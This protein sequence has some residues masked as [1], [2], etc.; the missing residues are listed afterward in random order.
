[1]GFSVCTTA[2]QGQCTT[3]G[4]LDACK[5][6]T[7]GGPQPLPYP[8]IGMCSDGDGSSK[9]R[10]K[11]KNALRKGDKMSKSMG[12]NAGVA[13]G[14][15]KSNKFMG[16]VA[17]KN[18]CAKVKAEGKLWAHHTVP[19]EH[20]DGNTVGLQSVPCAPQVTLV[21]PANDNANGTDATGATSNGGAGQ[22]AGGGG[23]PQ[24]QNKPCACPKSTSPE[25]RQ[26]VNQPDANGNL[27]K[28]ANPLCRKT[29]AEVATSYATK[30]ENK[31]A[32]AIPGSKA[33]QTYKRKADWWRN[34]KVAKNLGA[35]HKYPA[36][37]IKA[38]PAFQKVEATNLHKAKA[39]MTDQGNMQGLCI[40]CNSIKGAGSRVNLPGTARRLW[41]S[42]ILSRSGDHIARLIRGASGG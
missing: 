7:P 17:L 20:N 4:P 9:V 14:G 30:W 13:G 1:M 35:D 2:A 8:N 42:E 21:G 11:S 12:D 23:P 32:T 39:I 26:A 24:N 5:T 34:S 22:G 31:L 3:P 37:K 36:S 28:C 33:A 41:D 38:N 40:I 29:A 25:N 16:K 19:T 18:G 15:V 27:P 10:V 6:P